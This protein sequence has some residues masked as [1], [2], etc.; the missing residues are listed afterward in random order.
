VN[1]NHTLF[2][3]PEE[4]SKS[5][6]NDGLLVLATF[7]KIG[8]ENNEFEKLVQCLH[9]VHLKNQNISVD[10]IIIKNLLP[11]MHIYNS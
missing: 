8:K 11:G 1:W 5:N 4:A 10:H 2:K 6:E 9:D 7:V 3:T